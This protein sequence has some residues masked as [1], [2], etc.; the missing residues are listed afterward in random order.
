M[1]I[2]DFSSPCHSIGSVPDEAMRTVLPSPGKAFV[3]VVS[4]KTGF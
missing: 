3:G 4:A 2:G 1:N